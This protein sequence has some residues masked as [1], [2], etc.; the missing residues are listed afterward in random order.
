MKAHTPTRSVQ[1]VT[2][3]LREVISYFYLVRLTLKI[4]LSPGEPH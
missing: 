1:T 4:V 3:E 2:L